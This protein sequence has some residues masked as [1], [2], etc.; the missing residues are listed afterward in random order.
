MAP[1]FGFSPDM[2]YR[3]GAGAARGRAS[4]PSATCASHPASACRSGTTTSEQEEIYVLLSGSA[5][6]K[7]DDEMLELSRWTRCGSPAD[8]DARARGR[9]RTGCE[10]LLFGAPNVG[11]SDAEMEQGWWA[12]SAASRRRGDRVGVR[13][14]PASAS[15]ECA[16]AASGSFRPCPVTMQTTSDPGSTCSCSSAAMP[17]ADAGSQKMPSSAARSRHAAISSSSGTVTTC[18]PQPSSASSP[19][20]RARA[21]RSG[22]RSPS[23]SD[24][25]PPGRHEPRHTLARLVEAA[26]RTPS[27]CRRRRRAARRRRGRGRAPR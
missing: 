9:A 13:V 5:R 7:L 17:A 4:P 20:R 12:T 21:R 27:C 1:K 15:G 23:W 19:R 8:D 25:A 2:E 16:A 22:S 11:S 14:R 26:R 3:A 6:L 24:A 18:P 10:L